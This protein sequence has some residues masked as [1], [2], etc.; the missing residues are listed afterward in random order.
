MITEAR[1]EAKIENLDI[2]YKLGDSKKN[3]CEIFGK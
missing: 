3:L 2:I 1:N